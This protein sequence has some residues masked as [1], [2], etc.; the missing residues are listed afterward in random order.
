[1]SARPAPAVPRLPADAVAPPWRPREIRLVTVPAPLAPA[2]ALLGLLPEGPAFFWADAGLACCGAGSAALLT[3]AG[4]DRVQAIES[5]ATLLWPRV[6]SVLAAGAAPVPPRVFGGFSFLPDPVEPPWKELG[7]AAFVLP[8]LLYTRDQAGARLSVAVSAEEAAAGPTTVEETLETAL[9]ALRASAGSAAGGPVAAPPGTAPRLVQ[10]TRR[11][12]VEWAA[13]VASIQE[14]IRA[15]RA[16]K[17]VAAR[18]REFRLRR[19]ADLVA[20]L[21]RLAAEP[22]ALRF[23]FRLARATIL[24]ATPERLVARRGAEVRTEALAGSR[25]AGRAG[26][27]EELRVSPK[28]AAEHRLVVD[29]IAQ[30]LRPLCVRLDHPAEPEIH[31]LRHVLHLRTP[32]TGTLAGPT[33]VLELVARLHPTP[34]VGGTPTAEAMAWIRREEGLGRGWYAAPIGWFDPTGDGDFRVA[35]RSA[36]L[37]GRTARLYAGAG[38]VAGSDAAAELAETETKLRTMLDALG[39]DP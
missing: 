35:L 14:L 13:R 15:G 24:G 3:A 18:A 30:A 8:R 26:R 27:E 28:D 32:F 11:D 5:A 2:E 25:P 19:P 33:H 1:M 17:V 12:R 36:L 34:A 38:I 37:D 22:S 23:A 6:R 39:A 9:A 10:A 31:R 21:R 7:Q 20:V 29:A 16:E 4:P